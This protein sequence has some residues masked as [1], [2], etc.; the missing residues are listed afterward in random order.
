MFIITNDFIDEGR[1]VGV[2]GPKGLSDNNVELLKGIANGH[3][4]KDLEIRHFYL[5]DGDQECYYSG[6]WVAGDGG[7]EF[8]ALDCFGMPNAGCVT[9][10][11]IGDDGKYHVI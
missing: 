11:M 9:I 6:Y 5:Y 8:Q 3:G 4:P 2:C 7:D 10:K 1:S